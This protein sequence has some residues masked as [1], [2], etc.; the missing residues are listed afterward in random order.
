MEYEKVLVGD[1]YDYS[2][3]PGKHASCW[4]FSQVVIRP[5]LDSLAPDS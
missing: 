4:Q 3:I 5:V 1:I 2:F